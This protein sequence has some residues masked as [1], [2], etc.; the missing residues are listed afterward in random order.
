MVTGP[1]QENSYLI[2]NSSNRQTILVDPGD[3]CE[4]INDQIKLNK[5]TP[6]AIINTLGELASIRY[7]FAG[8]GYTATPTLTID[9]PVKA[10]ISSGSYLFKE[11]VRGV[12]TGTTA[13]VASWDLDDRILKVTNVGGVGFA[14]GE[15]VVG[16]GTSLLG[17]DAEY[18]VRSV[19]DQDEYDLYNENIAVE[20]EADS[21]ID[22]S[23][24]NPFGDF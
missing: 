15:S 20:S 6:I 23:E 13:I 5:L 19:S 10:G 22:F 11:L 17:S 1:F 2:W 14:P 3:D 18:V 8:I 24:E 16:I 21:I 7:S 4:L 9:P 12:S